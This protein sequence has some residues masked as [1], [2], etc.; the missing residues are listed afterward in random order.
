SRQ[1]RF[2][3]YVHPSVEEYLLEE[4]SFR[5]KLLQKSA[6]IKIDLKKDPD[7]PVEEYRIFS[8]KSGADI[9]NQFK[10]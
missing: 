1:R 4:G 6:K 8:M 7:L 5:L 3:L 9:T 10:A 2:L